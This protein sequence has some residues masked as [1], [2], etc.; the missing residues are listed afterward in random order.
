MSSRPVFQRSPR[1]H[2]AYPAGEAEIPG[3]PAAPSAPATSLV[4]VLLPLGGTVIALAIAVIVGSMAG[5]SG[6]LLSMAISMPLMIT[7]YVVSYVNYATQRR[8]Y[9]RTCKERETRY[10]AIL[11]E[12][13]R[14]LEEVRSRLRAD[15]CGNDP[16]PGECLAR[17]QQLDRRLWERS[18][19]DQDFLSLRLGLGQRPFPVRFKTPK[20]RD[21]FDVDPLL[22]AA[23]ALAVDFSFSSDV[24]VVLPLRTAGAVGLVGPRSATIE[25]VRGLTLQLATHH[26][27][28][29]VR[30]G[31]LFPAGEECHWSWMRWLPHTRTEDGSR[32]LLASEK[33]SA[34]RL[35]VDLGDRLGQ[36]LRLRDSHGQV[37][38]PAIV[39]ILADGALVGSE[40]V[41]RRLL[42]EGPQAQAYPVFL[43]DRMESLPKGCTTIV[44]VGEPR[45]RLI[46]TAEALSEVAFVPD[47]V[48]LEAA[49][50]LART[51]APVLL[52]KVA[53]AGEL[54]NKVTL[55]GLL[56]VGR[57]EELD[58]RSRWAASEPSES[59][60][61]PIG[62]RT[63]D[64]VLAL[65]LHERA[66]GP[67]GLVA[68]TTGSGKSELL[69]SLIASCAVR[70][71]PHDVAFLLV[72]FKGGGMADAFRDLP[73]L[74]GAITNLDGNLAQR[75]LAA[76]RGE[77]R[78]RQVLF[79]RSGVNDISDYQRRQKRGQ[80][81]DPLPH[82]IIV[83]DEF[84]EMAKAQPAFL[85]ELVSV[86]RVGRSLGVHLILATQ[87]PA[88]VISEQIWSNARFRVCLR[89][90]QAPD[91]QEVLKR[92]DAALLARI[93]GRGY[94]QVG[95]NEVF[96]LFQAAWAGAPYAPESEAAGTKDAIL[97]VALDGSKRVLGERPKSPG[98][99]PSLTQL[100]ALVRYLA[101]VAERDGVRRLPGPWLAPL[102]HVVE[103]RAVLDDG[104][105]RDGGGWDGKTWRP[106]VGWVAP[107]VGLV[108]NPG[109]QSQ[110]PLAL[111]LG[112]EGHLAVY[113]GPGAGK[114]TFIQTLVVSLAMGHSPED[115]SIYLLDFG[116]RLLS[117]FEALPHVGG[118]VQSDEGERLS[119]LLRLLLRELEDRK[120]RFARAGVTTLVAYRA[121]TGEKLPAIVIAL[122]NYAGL[123]GQYP[124][125]EDSLAQLAREG[126]NFG[127]HLVVTANGP[128][129]VRVKIAGNISLTVA[130][131]LVEPGDYGLAV[132]RTEG[133]IPAPTPGRGLVKG[134]PPL[135]FQTALP[136]LGE[137]EA[138]RTAALRKLA[139][140]MAEAWSGPRATPIPVLPDMVLLKDL[141]PPGQAWS[142][143]Q[144]DGSLSVPI[145]IDVEELTT[146]TVD[147]RDGPHFLIAGPGQSGKTTLLQSWLLALAETY[148][149]ADLR[150]YLVDFRRAGLADL[151]SLPHVRALALDEESLG[152]ALDEIIAEL[153]RR[154][155]PASSGG[156]AGPVSQLPALV[157]A[158]DDFFTVRDLAQAEI[159]D[160]LEQIVRRERGLGVHLLLTGAT[161][162]VSASWDG[163][164]KSLREMQT[165]FCLGSSDNADLN[166]FNLRVPLEKANRPLPAG[167][168]YLARRGKYR[169]V[170]VGMAP[171]PREWA[172]LIRRREAPA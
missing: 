8:S 48:P 2:P 49:D 90:E 70:F 51:L 13:R 4:T 85:D 11:E 165:G 140:A 78:R 101:E 109:Q 158:I 141:V 122:D 21:A 61:A 30:V 164:V 47:E 115:V 29:E 169:I 144:K 139:L 92:P 136:V 121:T 75:A 73:H 67:H 10:R 16:G 19:L 33:D 151:Q 130:L 7:S 31:A 1:L 37:G 142:V 153:G 143:A 3:I 126:G 135:E 15:L 5:S 17:C 152:K 34:H 123:A 119:R 62:Q 59:L 63:G 150:L 46:R 107:V 44:V 161:S 129:S 163:W 99:Q 28:D 134:T 108:D 124:D 128:T 167:V 127:L 43:A 106:A 22:R 125:A 84:A 93:G 114:T 132:G 82:L 14:S 117:A 42:E 53:E 54:P 159:K 56:G 138:A 171:K 12:L 79:A 45:G 50:R 156:E 25:A 110:G 88:G 38:G 97:E 35:L 39:L 148:S 89:V 41:L 160:R 55:L 52:K 71:H 116:G 172:D 69:Q 154:R 9:K 60:A 57:V 147:L 103:L 104:G 145:G 111:D 162:D 170:K 120:E 77:L 32:R 24:P 40:P 100:Q 74:V 98:G 155:E 168:G 76:M 96:E 23:Q 26:S 102:P 137:G 86:A 113:G 81:L 94:L 146:V 27:P 58:V 65:D 112:R 80:T 64:E 166:L 68:G 133:L 20:P 66:H 18:P 105:V 72:D 157:L 87:K 131:Q 83:V 6:L 149:P 118:V 36:R 91:S 95:N